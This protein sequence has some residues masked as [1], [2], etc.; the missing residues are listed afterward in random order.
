MY[1]RR[2][3]VNLVSATV[4]A[5][6]TQTSLAANGTTSA[7]SS[8]VR[9]DFP[10]T[11][12]FAFLNSSYIG[13]SPQIVVD[14]AKAFLQAK[15]DNP[16]KLGQMLAM[17]SDVRGKFAHLV[18]AESGE[19]GLLSTT[20]EGENIVTA[21]MDLRAGDNVVI[22]SLHFDTSIL[23]YEHLVKTRGIELRIVESV[24]GAVRPEDFEKYVD[25]RTRLISVA[26]VSHQNGYRHDLKSLADLAHANNAYLYVDAIQGVGTLELDVRQTGI[27]FFAAGGYKWLYAGFGVAPFF[28]RAALLDKIEPDRI[29]WRQVESETGPQQV[30]FYKDARKFGYATPA[31]AAIYQLN[32]AL[33]YLSR[34]DGEAIETHGVSLANRLNQSLREQG[35]KVLTPESNRSTIVAFQH[36]IDPSKAKQAIDDAKIQVSF[37]EEDSQIR[38][39]IAVFNN[40][41]DID[42]LLSITNTWM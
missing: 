20:S 24:D 13:P 33:D 18:N 14:A 17:T 7:I 37:R 22:D 35:F 36:G 42:R 9:G 4:T 5:S 23:L 2:D 27:D 32:A 10:V 3:F 30:E 16:V 15:A 25:A 29:G 41:E 21:A 31:F 28:I 26:W 6:V 12:N 11:R 39:G 38:A 34:L 8:G 19:I 1:T 40:D